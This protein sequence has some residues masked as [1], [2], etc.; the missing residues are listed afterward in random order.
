MTLPAWVAPQL[1][2]L[3]SGPPTGDDWVHEI[4]LDGYRLLLRRRARARQAPHAQRA[5]LDGSLPRDRRGGGQPSR[6][7]GLARRRDRRVRRRGRLEL[8]GPAAGCRVRIPHLRRVRPAIRRRTRP[9]PGAAARAEESARAS[10]RRPARPAALLGTLRCAG[11][12]TSTSAPAGCRSR[13]SSP[14]GRTRPTRRGAATTWLKVK[15][16]ARQEF[17]I[18]GYTDPRGRAQLSSARCCSACTSETAPRLRGQG[19][20]RVRRGHARGA[21]PAAPEARAGDVA[22]R[23]STA[24][25]RRLAERT[26]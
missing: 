3:V 17:V 25:R 26:G 22:V 20:D 11:A 7:G 5:G 19:G 18:G 9:A 6:E 21:R 14:S 13:A 12:T 8:P 24:A 15:C 16:M 4:K 2:T 23:D 1:A 10:A